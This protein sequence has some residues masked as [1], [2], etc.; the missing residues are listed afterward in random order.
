MIGKLKLF[1]LNFFVVFVLF[2]VIFL[3]S[4]SSKKKVPYDIK[5]DKVKVY[6]R[7]NKSI[8]LG[9]AQIKF[10]G[11]ILKASKIEYEELKGLLYAFGNV[12]LISRDK[13]TIFYADE[14]RYEYRKEYA[15]SYKRPRVKIK[16]D[17]IF[18]RSDKAF[19]Y[20]AENKIIFK[21]RFLFKQDLKDP[22]EITGE[23]GIYWDDIKIAHVEGKVR[24]KNKTQETTA[25]KLIYYETNSVVEFLSNVVISDRK[26]S[27]TNIIYCDFSYYFFKEGEKRYFYSR[28]NVIL[29]SVLEK[30][31]VFSDKLDYYPDYTYAYILP[32]EEEEGRVRLEQKSKNDDLLMTSERFEYWGDKN[33]FYAKG[34]VVIKSGEK[35][36][37]GD[38]CVYYM[39]K[40]FVNLSGSPYMVVNQDEIRSE[41]IR[42][43]LDTRE[44]QMQTKINGLF[45]NTSKN[46]PLENSF[47]NAFTN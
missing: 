46:Q 33:K 28:T 4:K 19:S 37:Y 7:K 11:K 12:E 38:F 15:Y 31:K 32:Q 10:E 3:Y 14:L 35:T 18:I 24:V 20:L 16:S 34:D 42:Y 47:S 40:R 25:N 5:A 29:E 13:N 17:N 26:D 36:A 23:Q 43:Y 27:D 9:N 44:F 6:T 45:Q 1:F 39:D 30:T 21:K 2:H 22:L 41:I 8:L